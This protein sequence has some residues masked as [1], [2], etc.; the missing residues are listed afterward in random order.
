MLY[1]GAEIKKQKTRRRNQMLFIAALI[2]WTLIII[3]LGYVSCDAQ[4]LRQ[5]DYRAIKAE[6]AKIIKADQDRLAAER[7]L[8]E[9]VLAQSDEELPDLLALE[10]LTT[11]PDH[12][13][14]K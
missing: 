3:G 10:E 6:M 5:D 11:R 12:Q 1:E 9:A 13:R 4:E 7:A 8:D 14:E 2:L